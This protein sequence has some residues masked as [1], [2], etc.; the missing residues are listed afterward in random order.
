MCATQSSDRGSAGFSTQDGAARPFF[1][2]YLS[3]SAQAGYG[4][5]RHGKVRSGSAGQGRASQGVLRFARREPKGSF[6]I[7]FKNIQ[8]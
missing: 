3:M 7:L 4:K 1:M 6:F 8:R 2:V 5:V